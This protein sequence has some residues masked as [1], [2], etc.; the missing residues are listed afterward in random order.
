MAALVSILFIIG[1]FAT[2]IKGFG[3]DDNDNTPSAT[4]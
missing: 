2:V 4:A 1:V 3:E